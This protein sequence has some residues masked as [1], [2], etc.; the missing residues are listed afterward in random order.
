MIDG[1]LSFEITV[2]EHYRHSYQLLIAMQ[3]QLDIENSCHTKLMHTGTR[4]SVM[5]TEDLKYPSPIN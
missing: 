1:F 5:E 2:T 4:L 3:K